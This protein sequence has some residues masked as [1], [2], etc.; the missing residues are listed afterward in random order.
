MVG[1]QA[2]GSDQ[3]QLEAAVP[4]SHGPAEGLFSDL[5]FPQGEA[6]PPVGATRAAALIRGKPALKLYGRQLLNC[7]FLPRPRHA[8]ALY[9]CSVTP[10]ALKRYDEAFAS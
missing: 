7:P 6:L 8:E 2:T 5:G 9:N 10:H 4:L 3:A 1:A